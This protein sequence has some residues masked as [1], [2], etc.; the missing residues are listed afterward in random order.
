M[1]VKPKELK[2]FCLWVDRYFPISIFF[3]LVF[4]AYMVIQSPNDYLQGVYSKIMFLH[5]P[6]AWLAMLCYVMLSVSSA[7]FIASKSMVF[8]IVAVSFAKIGAIFCLMTLITG[9]LWGKP[10]WGVFWAWDARLTSMLLLQFIYVIYLTIRGLKG[11]K[12]KLYYAAAVFAIIG[13][14]NI[15]IIKFSVNLWA[16]L[17]QGASIIKFGGP[18]V[19]ST[20]LW[21]LVV[22]VLALFAVMMYACSQEILIRLHASKNTS[23]Y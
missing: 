7:F 12:F 4:A 3:A 2:V 16:T 1:M 15:P 18:S 10:T 19:H 22:C 14:I 8:D 20:M 13:L 6:S 5:I 21:P 11:I 23:K 17:H 9:S